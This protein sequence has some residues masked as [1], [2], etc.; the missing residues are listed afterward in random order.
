MGDCQ[1]YQ[2]TESGW[3]WLKTNGGGGVGFLFYGAIDDQMAVASLQ[4]IKKLESVE[5]CSTQVH[6]GH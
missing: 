6:E 2:L 5:N 1:H 3:V 4:Q